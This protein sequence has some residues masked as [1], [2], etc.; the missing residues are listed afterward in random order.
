M[1]YC[2]DYRYQA[3]VDFGRQTDY[4]T[5]A[6]YRQWVYQTCTEFGWF[7]SSDQPGHPY[8]TKIS[9]ELSLKVIQG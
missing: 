6:G 1:E 5:A 3:L 9:L 4:K 7:D 2:M 8:G